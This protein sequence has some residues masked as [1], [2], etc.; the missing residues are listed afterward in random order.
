MYIDDKLVKQIGYGINSIRIK[1]VQLA[2]A[3]RRRV[4]SFVVKLIAAA[5]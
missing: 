3:E 5:L 4:R 2:F 1:F